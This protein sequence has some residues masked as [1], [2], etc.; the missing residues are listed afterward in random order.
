[1]PGIAST[2]SSPRRSPVSSPRSSSR[3]D[4]QASS[5]DPTSTVIVTPAEAGVQGD[6]L[7]LG[8]WIPAFAGMTRDWESSMHVMYFTEQPMSAYPADI[9]LEV[10]HTA[11]MFSNKYFD[12]VAG[13]R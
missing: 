11:L 7:K 4:R 12:P 1:R 3:T 8:P 6:R 13:S 2:W 10:G 5:E 9:G